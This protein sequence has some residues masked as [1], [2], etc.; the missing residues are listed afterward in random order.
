MSV[1]PESAA[2][3]RPTSVRH[4]V[5]FLTTSM[6][7][8]LYLDRFSLGFV[9]RFIREDLRLNQDEISVLISVFFL[10]Y[11]LGQVPCGWLSDRWGARRMLSLYILLWS[12]A[13]GFLGLSASFFAVLALRFGCGL[14]QAG[15]YPTCGGILSVWVPLKRRGLASSIVSN[16]GRVG[17]VLAPLLTAYLVVAFVPR[18]APSLLTSSDI[19]NESELLTALRD[20][21]AGKVPRFGERLRTFWPAATEISSADL[22]DG[23]NAVLYKPEL[24]QADDF[25]QFPLEREA[26][27][28]AEIPADRRTTEQ[29]LR[30]N[31]L[32]LEAVYPS[33]IRKLYGESW[34]PVMLFYGGVGVVVAGLFWFFYR[35][36]PR[37]HPNCNEAELALIEAG[38]PPAT[39]DAARP[40]PRF[41]WRGV[42]ANPS[43]WLISMSQF[44]TNFSWVFIVNNLPDYLDRVHHVPVL[45]RGWMSSL[46]IVVGIVGM[47]MGGW[48]TDWLAQRLGIRWGRSLPLGGSRLIAMVACAACVWWSTAWSVTI[49][50][51]VVAWATDLG[52]PAVWAYKQEVG[53]RYV[54]SILG[55]GN[56]WG[57]YGSFISPLVLNYMEKHYGWGAVFWSLAAGFFLAGVTALP[58]DARSKIA[59]EEVD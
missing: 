20:T 1:S 31:R 2:A 5:V 11:A 41:P 13:T 3:E 17:G 51:C 26:V 33:Y 40:M 8:M 16:G 52:V 43:L 45:Q 36:R 21:G 37:L 32:L 12:L 19:L 38:R 15:A 29:T 4:W 47:M 49:A 27:R 46:P 18:S 35:D 42:L 55:W 50:L 6:A 10:S 28:L 57:N 25:D 34:R 48:L 44:T 7:L 14:A 24:F 23:L 58:V 53:G 56:M 22:V 30:L 54:G 59:P 9:L 39:L